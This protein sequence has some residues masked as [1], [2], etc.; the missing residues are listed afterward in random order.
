M[1]LLSGDSSMDADHLFR[2]LKNAGKAKQ[3]LGPDDVLTLHDYDV[4]ENLNVAAFLI[5]RSDP[6]GVTQMYEHRKTNRIRPSDRDP[7]E[8]VTTTAHMFVRLPRKLDAHPSYDVLIEEVEGISRSHVQAFVN[9]MLGFHKYTYK[10]RN[11]DEK[12]TKSVVDLDGVPSETM[13][14]ALKTA[15]INRVMLVRPGKL[16]GLDGNIAAPNEEVLPL[17]IKN[18]DNIYETLTQI[19]RLA[20]ADGWRDVR[21]RVEM[22]EGKSRVVSLDREEDAATA[23]FIRAREVNLKAPLPSCSDKISR[24]LMTKA[25]GLFGTLRDGRGT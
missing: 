10:D 17:K 11:G 16:N 19:R 18:K 5:R 25:A 12:E 1:P 15:V 22:Q 14:T 2:T 6:R 9:F 4:F 7:L 23:L 21:V 20:S 8:S 13:E 24:E 3:T